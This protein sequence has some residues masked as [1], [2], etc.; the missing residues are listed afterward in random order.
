MEKLCCYLGMRRREQSVGGASVSDQNQQQK[1]HHQHQLQGKIRPQ[2]VKP[3]QP[4][5]VSVEN[6]QDVQKSTL[7]ARTRLATLA[8]IGEDWLYLALLGTIMAL[9]SFSMDSVITLFLNT[10]LW[11][12][13]DLSEDNRLVQY[14]GW[15]LTPIILVTFSSGFVHLCSPTVSVSFVYVYYMTKTSSNYITTTTF[16]RLLVQ[17][18]LR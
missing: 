15:C 10:R 12:F 2:H 18:Y 7:T 13:K 5:V 14:V 9:L 17:V 11:L 6:S 4:P 1:Q 8:Q 16:Q 3:S